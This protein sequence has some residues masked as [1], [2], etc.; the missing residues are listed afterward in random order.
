MGV[1]YLSPCFFTLLF[2][3]FS[4]GRR[5]KERLVCFRVDEGDEKLFVCHRSK[6]VGCLFAGCSR[7]SESQEFLNV[8]SNRHRTEDVQED[9]GTIRVIFSIQISMRQSLNH[10]DWN[11]GQFSDYSFVK[12]VFNEKHGEDKR[13]TIRNEVNVGIER[14]RNESL[15]I[16]RNDEEFR[17]ERAKENKHQENTI[18]S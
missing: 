10:W 7:R 8:L 13:K 1:T 2:F 5:Q 12:S 6:E 3:K 4:W 17:N 14:V 11:E 15:R 9:E 18:E 16:K